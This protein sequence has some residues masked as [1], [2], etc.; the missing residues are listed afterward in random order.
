MASHRVELEIQGGEA[1][2]GRL[3]VDGFVSELGALRTALQRTDRMVSA[4]R[5]T[6]EW[7]V[8]R[9]STESP[10]IVGMEARL[11]Q[12]VDEEH[13]RRGKIVGTFFEYIERLNQS[14]DA[15]D[16]L[17]RSTL[18]AYRALG[19][20][21]SQKKV[22]AILRNTDRQVEV[23]STLEKNIDAVL[24]PEDTAKGSVKGRLE[25]VNIHGDKHVFK[26]YPAVGPSSIECSFPSDRIE[27]AREGL[28]STVRVHGT[29]TF[30][31]R[32]KYPSK[33]AVD[34]ID[35]LPPADD[36]PSLLDLK[37]AAP[38]ALDGEASEDYIR[39]Q[40]DEW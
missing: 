1:T 34:D 9:L 22:R 3:L 25:Y 32:S 35:V 2:E 21:V 14:T 39:R 40:R 12:T 28:G 24:E 33:V 36:L 20:A 38:D 16:E 4:G 23:R 6:S 13:D 7:E 11:K 37:G 18:K 31:A 27:D 19:K 5:I 15:P 30:P 17:N 8:V 10:A 26:I 29:L